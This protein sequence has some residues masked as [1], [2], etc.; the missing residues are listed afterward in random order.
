MNGMEIAIL[1]CVILILS[2]YNYLNFF[3]AKKMLPY[4]FGFL[5]WVMFQHILVLTNSIV[6]LGWVYGVSTFIG[7]FFLSNYICFPIMF[8]LHSITGTYRKM[9]VHCVSPPNMILYA[10]WIVLTVPILTALTII[11]F[12]I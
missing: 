3:Y 2:F 8:I 11:N 4:R 10:C 12:F 9:K 1:I 5:Q 6:F 7:L